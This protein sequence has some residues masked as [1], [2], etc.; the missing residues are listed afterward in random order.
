MGE[1]GRA[2]VMAEFSLRDS[3]AGL[4]ASFAAALAADSDS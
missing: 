1:A 2:K 3:A 4:R